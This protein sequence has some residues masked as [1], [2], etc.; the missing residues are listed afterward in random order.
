MKETEYPPCVHRP[1]SEE[2]EWEEGLP[3]GTELQMLDRELELPVP[4]L[5]LNEIARGEFQREL[6]V[7]RIPRPETTPPGARSQCGGPP[8]YRANGGG[9]GIR[10][11]EKAAEGQLER[12]TVDQAD[13]DFASL[14]VPDFDPWA[15]QEDVYR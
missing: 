15:G 2:G 4:G 3:Y 7:R 14:E 8:P 1:E 5:W 6:S 9:Y 10:C 13:Y 12:R 11:E